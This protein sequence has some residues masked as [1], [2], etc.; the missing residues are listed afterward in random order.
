MPH[1]DCEVCKTFKHL[2]LLIAANII[3]D[4]PANCRQSIPSTALW[5]LDFNQLK[6]WKYCRIYGGFI[7]EY[8]IFTN[9][10]IIIIPA[11]WPTKN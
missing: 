9:I 7:K 3:N 6:V 2:L 11:E 10:Q 4:W 5:M 1:A 8:L